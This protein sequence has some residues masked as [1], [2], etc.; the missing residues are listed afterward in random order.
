M[1]WLKEYGII[2]TNKQKITVFATVSQKSTSTQKDF[3]ISKYLWI[4]DW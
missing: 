4:I 3:E 1:N 2:Y